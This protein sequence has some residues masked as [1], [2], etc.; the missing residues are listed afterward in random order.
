LTLFVS[1]SSQRAAQAD[2]EEHHRRAR[3]ESGFTILEV[4]I[5]S[6]LMVVVMTG[7]LGLF[8][9]SSKVAYSDLERNISLS[10]E[11]SALSRITTELRQAYQVN[12]PTG[13]CTN[14]ATANS[15][16][17]DE[18]IVTSTGQQDR[19][20]AYLCKE[21][22]PKTGW[23]ECVRYE[24]PNTATV[25]SA[26][27]VTE[28]VCKSSV[29]LPRIVNNTTADPEDPVFTGLKSGAG[30]GSTWTWGQVTIKTPT[31]GERT[32]PATYYKSYVTLSDSFYMYQLD[33][34]H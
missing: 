25:P 13:G 34:G 22:E 10:E 6:I 27:C 5:S 33:Y 11:A 26:T 21:A 23:D 4:L 32:G 29:V 24:A 28:K 19:R 7:V 31:G 17:F 12:C 18:R 8:D 3:G 2:S 15:I 20:V 16:D 9:R 14:N 1:G 30:L